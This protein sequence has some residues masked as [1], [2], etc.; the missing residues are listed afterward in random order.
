MLI[1]MM[2]YKCD[3]QV[4]KHKSLN[5]EV[6][7]MWIELQQVQIV[8][9]RYFLHIVCRWRKPYVKRVFKIHAIDF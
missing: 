7:G 2:I 6:G 5:Q 8:S 9:A 3:G 1:L 4:L